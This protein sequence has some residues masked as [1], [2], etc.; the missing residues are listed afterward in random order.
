MDL[1]TTL[2]QAAR[3]PTTP[4]SADR[5]STNSVRMLLIGLKARFPPRPR[6]RVAGRAHLV[7]ADDAA[8]LRSGLRWQ[9]PRRVILYG[10]P[11]VGDFS[12]FT[13]GGDHAHALFALHASS[14]RSAHPAGLVAANAAT[15][16]RNASAMIVFLMFS[17]CLNRIVIGKLLPKASI[18]AKWLRFGAVARPGSL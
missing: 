10:F 3:W 18:V 9:Y 8:E 15:G 12:P 4:T 1:D 5:E 17:S 7:V 6:L 13:I 11:V 2:M 16:V 14:P